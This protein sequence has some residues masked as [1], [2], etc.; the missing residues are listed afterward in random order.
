MKIIDLSDKNLIDQ[1]SN[2]NSPN[3]ILQTS[4]A[5]LINSNKQKMSK[6]RDSLD[7]DIAKKLE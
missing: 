4:G 2:G 6:K 7:A 3:L 5:L 1:V